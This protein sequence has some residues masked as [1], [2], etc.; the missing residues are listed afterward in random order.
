LWEI[1][2]LGVEEDLVKDHIGCKNN[3]S[4]FKVCPPGIEREK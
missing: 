3:S 4:L 1:I 2:R